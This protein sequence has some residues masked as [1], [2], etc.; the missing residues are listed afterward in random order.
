MFSIGLVMF[1]TPSKQIVAHIL[2]LLCGYTEHFKLYFFCQFFC[3]WIYLIDNVLNILTRIGHTVMS[4]EQIGHEPLITFSSYT[5]L[6]V[7]TVY[8]AVYAVAHS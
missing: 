2:L 6:K 1:S 8:F 3:V 5:L 7:Y 4:G